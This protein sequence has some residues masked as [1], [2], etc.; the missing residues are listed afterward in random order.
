MNALSISFTLSKSSA[1]SVN[2]E[3]N[4]REY[5]AN[6]VDYARVG[7]NEVYIIKDLRTMY[8][9]LFSES[10]AEY[11]RNQKQPCRRIDDY[12]EH[13]ANGRREEVCYEV[14]V[15]FGDVH[16]AGN[17]TT[18]GELAAKML[19]EYVRGFQARNPNLAVFNLVT[20][21][22]ESSP[23]CH[24]SF[25]PVYTQGRK[26]GLSTGVSM[27][28]A[29]DEMGFV[30]KGHRN[31]RLVAWEHRERGELEKIL[32]R[33]GI[34]REVKNDDSVHQSVDEYKQSQDEKKLLALRERN[35]VQG[36]VS[37][38]EAHRLNREVTLLK[39][40]VN[41]LEEQSSS[42]WKSFYYTSQDKQDYVT[43]E[44]DRLNISYRLS[45]NGFEAQAFNVEEIR[46]IEK[47]FKAPAISYRDELRGHLDEL[48][49]Q[50]KDYDDLL[51]RLG[52]LGYTIKQGKYLAVLP[53]KGDKF[54]RTKSLGEEYSETA[55]RNRLVYK[56][57][58]ES[59]ID[60]KITSA[61]NPDSLNV[62]VIKTMKHYTIVFAQGLLPV[63]KRNKKKPFM[64]T[65]DTE[66][67]RLAE[68]NKKITDGVTAESLRGDMD[69]SQKSITDNEDKL[70]ELKKELDFFHELYNA[71]NRCFKEGSSNKSDMDYLAKHKVNAENYHRIQKLITANENEVAVLEDTLSADRAELKETSDTLTML[72]KVVAGTYVQ[73]LAGDEKH[74]AQSEY[75]RNGA[76]NA[77]PEKVAVNI[78]PP[79]PPR[80]KM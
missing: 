40:K 10:L 2:I 28:A 17:G 42:L 76:K 34:E 19:D 25:I 67:D 30:S 46:K 12:Y 68:L 51:R 80:P 74:R 64:W 70:T 4:N 57:Q 8:D 53:Q 55:I 43:S 21:K 23:H 54:I 60:N 13:I 7:D 29:L 18:G 1:G 44:L 5:Y 52:E 37:E 27:K 69:S 50:S 36:Y 41:R 65:N 71:G 49:M 24:I 48:T 59:N 79:P 22:D 33:H 73:S 16:N 62:A 35:V 14:V 63:R 78:I 75:I 6:N 77:E 20:H 38:D 47:T 31:N 45:E 61:A 3:H 32:N 66:L 11:N 39:D 15:Q 9:E 72:E 58:Y 26:N 56:Q